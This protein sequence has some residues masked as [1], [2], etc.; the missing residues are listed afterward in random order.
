ME[1]LSVGFSA[2][3]GDVEV[4]VRMKTTIDGQRDQIRQLNHETQMQRKE[5]EAVSTANMLSLLGE[6]KLSKYQILFVC[7]PEWLVKLAGLRI[8]QFLSKVGKEG[9]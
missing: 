4:M 1:L 3:P 7:N 8:S 5:I 2:L 9:L 6:Q